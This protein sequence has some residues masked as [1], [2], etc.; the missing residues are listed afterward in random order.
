MNA[1]MVVD[2]ADPGH[3]VGLWTGLALMVLGGVLVFVGSLQLMRWWLR[4]GTTGQEDDTR[5]R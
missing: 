3:L 2:Q 1:A 5:N 4:R